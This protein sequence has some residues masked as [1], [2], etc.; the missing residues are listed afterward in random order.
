MLIVISDNDQKL[1]RPWPVMEIRPAPLPELCM[2]RIDSILIA[3]GSIAYKLTPETVPS[4]QKTTLFLRF[5]R[6][7]VHRVQFRFRGAAA[8]I[9]AG[10]KESSGNFIPNFPPI[11]VPFGESGIFQNRYFSTKGKFGVD[12]ISR[13]D[14]S[15]AHGPLRV[16]ILTLSRSPGSLS[17]CIRLGNCTDNLES[18]RIIPRDTQ[19]NPL[20]PGTVSV[21]ENSAR[22]RGD[23]G[24]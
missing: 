16:D 2:R 24:R 1:V 14:L 21:R 5:R 10:R 23:T 11:P 22:I 4:V 12:S 18:L 8:A 15:Q 17:H 20:P 9:D 13:V 19:E 7:P 3:A 6:V